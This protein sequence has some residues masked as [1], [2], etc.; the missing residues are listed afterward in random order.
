M[1]R[2]VLEYKWYTI[3]IAKLRTLLSADTPKL[4][5]AEVAVVRCPVPVQDPAEE[6]M[7]DDDENYRPL[8]LHDTSSESVEGYLLL[9]NNFQLWKR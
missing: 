2:Y 7:S 9:C 6:D 1:D 4:L 5:Q 3:E 8:S